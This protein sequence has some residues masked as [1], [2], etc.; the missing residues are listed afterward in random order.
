MLSYIL[1]SLIHTISFW[2]GRVNIIDTF[3]LQ[4]GFGFILLKSL[5]LMTTLLRC[6]Q[7]I[8]SI[9]S[10]SW[11]FSRS[12]FSFAYSEPH[13]SLTPLI[14]QNHLVSSLWFIPL[15]HTIGNSGLGCLH[16]ISLCS[17]GTLNPGCRPF[18]TSLGLKAQGPKPKA[19]VQFNK[20]RDEAV[21]KKAKQVRWLGHDQYCRCTFVIIII[22][23]RFGYKY[24]KNW[25]SQW[26]K[27]MRMFRDY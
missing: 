19:S 7:N 9:W 1:L 25:K 15:A 3:I 2:V 26:F 16:W 14:S 13:N 12:N 11:Y 18:L 10:N 22:A 6:I 4:Y 27:H 8:S 23:L 20:V 5:V 21:Q 17:H 24:Q